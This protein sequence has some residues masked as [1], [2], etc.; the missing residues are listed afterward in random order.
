M[1]PLLTIRINGSPRQVEEGS[2]LPALVAAL[3]FAPETLLVEHNGTA[4]HR[5]EW[6]RC[7]L[8]EGDSLEFLRIAAGG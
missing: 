5:G 2:T 4:L 1:T 6:E 7:L 3:G 8:A